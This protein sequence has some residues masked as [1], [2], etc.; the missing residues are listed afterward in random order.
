MSK[1]LYEVAKSLPYISNKCK[2]HNI[3]KEVRKLKIDAPELN[4]ESHKRCN[5]ARD[6]VFCNKMKDD[7]IILQVPISLNDILPK[8]NSNILNNK[9]IANLDC[10]RFAY[11]N[12][13]YIFNN[14][15]LSENIKYCVSMKKK[16]F[17]MFI[18]QEYCVVEGKDKKGKKLEYSTHSTCLFMIPNETREV[19][20]SYDAFYINSHG[21]DMEDTNIFKRIV[22]RKRTNNIKFDI[23][24]ELLLIEN[25]TDYWNKQGD[26]DG[27]KLNIYWDDTEKHTY[28]NSNLQS[29]D[30]Y[31]VCFAFPQIVFHHF[32][33]FYD[34][35]QKISTDWGEIIIN[36]GENLL[37][38]GKLALFIK[39]AF[40]NYSKKYKNKFIETTLTN[41]YFDECENDIL[42]LSLMEDNTGF[43]KKMIFYLTSYI[44]EL[45]IKI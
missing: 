32:G 30:N 17:I 23:P 24:V 16:I 28:F 10:G 11:S 25:L 29:G 21:R 1:T 12:Q 44:K 26:Y 37:K 39:S 33:E 42:E 19:K 7:L 3:L 9:K 41:N 38:C 27:E 22:S 5:F 15:Y 36:S 4:T 43:L 8:Q 13:E 14:E 18:F 45:E 40:V 35:S 2:I 31:G 20:N 34:K 6:T